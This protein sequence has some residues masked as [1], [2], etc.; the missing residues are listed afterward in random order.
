MQR[1]ACVFVENCA[2]HTGIHESAAIRTSSNAR[3]RL[4]R[5]REWLASE[6]YASGEVSRTPVETD[7]RQGL[8]RVATVTIDRQIARHR[9]RRE[10]TT[11]APC[12][13]PTPSSMRCAQRANRSCGI[14]RRAPS[15]NAGPCAPCSRTSTTSS[16]ADREN[17][18]PVGPLKLAIYSG[19]HTDSPTNSGKIVPD[20]QVCD[21][22]MA[23]PTRSQ[24][25]LTIDWG[26]SN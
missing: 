18:H 22:G 25:H 9:P 13:L 5:A 26:D 19:E 15:S 17:R 24:P 7:P 16:S 14:L 23:S 2:L 12:R 20:R 8:G 6:A 1:A 11:R 10:L 3:S 21:V 4:R